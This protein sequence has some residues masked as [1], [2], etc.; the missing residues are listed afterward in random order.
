LL[1]TLKYSIA[2]SGVIPDSRLVPV[3]R[4]AALAN[5]GATVVT[6]TEVA[7]TIKAA[8]NFEVMVLSRSIA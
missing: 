2:A 6:A 5:I 3:R 1:D 7:A 4:L 8:L